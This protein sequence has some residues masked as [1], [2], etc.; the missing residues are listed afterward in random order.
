MCKVSIRGGLLGGKKEEK[1]DARTVGG[2]D[3]NLVYLYD[4]CC[5][6]TRCTWYIAVVGEPNPAEILFRLLQ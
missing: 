2:Y 3:D 6:F 4:R 5:C 1:V